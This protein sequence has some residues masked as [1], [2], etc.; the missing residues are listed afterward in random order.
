MNPSLLTEVQREV[1]ERVLAE[2]GARRQHLVVSLSGAHAYGFPSPDSDL[3]LKGIHVVP[4][5]ELLGLSPPRLTFDRLEVV[6]GVEIDYTS[7]ELQMALAGLLAG[8]GN[9]LER[10]LGKT[11]L[12][13]SPLLD[14]LRPLAHAALSRRFHRHYRGFAI[15]QLH[16]AQQPTATAKQMLYVLRT[17]LTGTHLL[18][19]GE[20]V[21]DLGAIC[22]AYELPEAKALIE[23]KR[24][25]EKTVLDAP[26]RERWLSRVGAVL[27][28][29]DD[30]RATSSLPE[31]PPNAPELQAWLVEVRRQRL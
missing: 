14:A 15:S 20:L 31:E 3:D 2:E 24:A 11:A 25:G 28:A 13:R 10:V 22:E 27:E 16:E 29:L 21:T 19:T 18:R 8:N 7:N 1:A 23:A 30:A 26:T 17:A 5:A 12:A 9:Y 6:D 4:T